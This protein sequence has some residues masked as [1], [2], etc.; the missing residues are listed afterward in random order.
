MACCRVT[1]DCVMNDQSRPESAVHWHAL[2]PQEAIARFGTDPQNGLGPE[3]ALQRLSH[4]GPNRLPPPARQPAWQRFLLQFHNVL[5]Y[6]MLGA[7]AVTAWLGHWVDTGVLLA[8]VLVNA[9]VGYIQEGKAEQALN[10]IQS[11]LS[12]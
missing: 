2:S 9:V 12:L 5:I 4:Y 11:M 10:A 8:A 3:Q 7:S 1:A 6:V